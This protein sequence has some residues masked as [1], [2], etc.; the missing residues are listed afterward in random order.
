MEPSFRLPQAAAQLGVVGEMEVEIERK[1]KPVKLRLQVSA[2]AVA[3][4]PDKDLSAQKHKVKDLFLVVARE[5]G[6]LDKQGH[7][8]FDEQQAA[9]WLLLT[10]T[11]SS[12][13]A[14]RYK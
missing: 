4:L 3:V 14:M 5:V 10:S 11:P 13:L 12:R 9:S 8:V 7:S 1:N 6:A 2:G